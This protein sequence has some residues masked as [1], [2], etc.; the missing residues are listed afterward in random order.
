MSNFFTTPP[1]TFV[2]G[3]DSGPGLSSSDGSARGSHGLDEEGIHFRELTDQMAIMRQIHTDF[4]DQHVKELEAAKQ[5]MEIKVKSAI[6]RMEREME[7][8]DEIN[9]RNTVSGM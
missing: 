1:F 3:L 2:S 6:E 7:E 9:E 4:V 8:K 5:E